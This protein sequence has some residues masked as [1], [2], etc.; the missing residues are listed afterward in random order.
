MGICLLV[1]ALSAA[2]VFGLW[3]PYPYRDLA[4]GRELFFLVISVDVV[5]GPLLTLVLFTPT[6]PLAE[7]R[8]DLALVVLIQLAALGYGLWTVWQ[9]RPLFLVAELDRFKVIALPDLRGAAL[10]GLPAGLRPHLLAGPTVVAI[11]APK[12]LQEKHRVLMESINGGPDFGERP[13]FYLPYV[14]ADARKSLD[15]AKQIAPFLA[16]YPDRRT[17]AQAIAAQTG[18]P[19]TELRFFPVVARQDWIAVL[20]SQGMIVGFLPGDGF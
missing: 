7:L 15:R 20:D 18:T 6:K 2:M 19:L 3:Y 17:E 8:R 14:G 16:K 13:D 4:G 12:D 11:R 10:D 5:C 1:A 9:A